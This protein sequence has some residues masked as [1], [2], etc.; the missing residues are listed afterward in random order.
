M[1]LFTVPGLLLFLLLFR[2]LQLPQ[3]SYA[4]RPVRASVVTA[5]LQCMLFAQG[6]GRTWSTSEILGYCC[7]T[8]PSLLFALGPRWLLAAERLHLQ[9]A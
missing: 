4:H 5:L 9:S 1:L 6:F 7:S 8:C 2:M 3:A